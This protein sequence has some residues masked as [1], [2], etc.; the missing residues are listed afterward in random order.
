MTHSNSRN[1]KK[2]GS[3]TYTITTRDSSETTENEKK[4]GSGFNTYTNTDFN[5]KIQYPKN[6][7][8]SET[9]LAQNVIVQF[10]APDTKDVVQP[11]GVLIAEIICRMALP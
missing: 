2:S 9:D 3:I 4:S 1:E 6:W 8:K 10:L 7:E 5:I 11:A